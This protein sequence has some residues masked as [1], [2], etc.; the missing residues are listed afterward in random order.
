MK[1]QVTSSNR[2]L[3]PYR[4]VM[5]L[6]ESIAFNYT[7]KLLCALGRVR[8]ANYSKIRA[9]FVSWPPNGHSPGTSFTLDSGLVSYNPGGLNGS[10][11]HLLEVCLK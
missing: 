2:I 5:L 7:V 4:M 1:L 11:Q 6:T 9:F 10:T 3:P 8:I